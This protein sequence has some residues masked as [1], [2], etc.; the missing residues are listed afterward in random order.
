MKTTF[1]LLLCI[2]T[3]VL[4]AQGL[5]VTA[6][7]TDASCTANGRLEVDVGGGSGNYRYLLLSA[8]GETFPP[9]GGAIFE[10]LSPCSYELIVVDRTSGERD[11]TE[12]DIVAPDDPLSVTAEFMECETRIVTTGGAP[13]Y[14]IR[15]T[16]GGGPPVLV[17]RGPGSVE[18]G[19]LGDDALSGRVTDQ[20]GN[21]RNFVLEGSST[22]VKDYD[23]AQTAD[24][25]ILTAND[26]LGPFSYTI[27][28]DAGSFVN[29][30]GLFPSSQVGCDLRVSITGSCDNRPLV[31]SQE[32]I[33][34]VELSCVN[35]SEGTITLD[36]SPPGTTPYSV[37]VLADGVRI[38]STDLFI[39][40]IPR[41]TQ[42]L[43][44]SAVDGCGEEIRGMIRTTPNRVNV[45]DNTDDCRDE[46]LALNVGRS[47][48][49]ETDTPITIT[50]STC[51]DS[52]PYV[53]RESRTTVHINQGT[54]P[55][56]YALTVED[57]CGDRF[58]CRDTVLLDLLPACDSIKANVVQRFRCENGTESRRSILDP[59]TRYSLYGPDEGLVESGN[60]TGV[61]KDLLP[62]VY[63]VDATSACIATSAEVVISGSR[64]IDPSIIVRPQ[65]RRMEGGGCRVA[66]E[67]SIDRTDGPYILER[68]DDPAGP[69]VLNNLG[70]STCTFTEIPSDLGPGDYRLSSQRLCGEKLF[71]LPDLVEERIDSVIPVHTCLD[72]ASMLVVGLRRTKNDWIRYFANFGVQAT[73]QGG[74]DDI[75]RVD[76]RRFIGNV[77]NDLAPGEHLLEIAV[78]FSKSNC[79]IDTMTFT[80]PDYQPV[81]LAVAGNFICS[82]TGQA[83]LALSPQSG[84]APY[85]VRLIDCDDPGRI[86]KTYQLEAGEVAQAPTSRRGT[87][88]YIVRDDCGITADFQVE[89]RSLTDGLRIDYNCSPAVELST[90]TLGGAFEWSASD[91]SVLSRNTGIV[92]PESLRDRTYTLEVSLGSCVE[93]ETVSLPGR[94]ILPRLTVGGDTIVQCGTDAIVLSATVD[95]ASTFQFA[96]AAAGAE[97]RVNEPGTYT[98]KATNDLGC[99]VNEDVTV[100]SVLRPS[101]EITIASQNCPG[102]PATLA[103]LRNAGEDISWSPGGAAHDVLQV[104][105]TG[106]YFVTA[107]NE[108]GCVGRD[109]FVYIAPAPLA[110]AVQID[111][112]SCFGA[113]DGAVLLNGTGGSGELSY[114]F[115]GRTHADG[116]LLP[117]V[118]AG[119]YRLTLLD[120]NGCTRDTTVTVAQPDSLYIDL[121]P[122]QFIILGQETTVPISSNFDGYGQITSSPPAPDSTLRTGVL[123]LRVATTTRVTVTATDL[124]GCPATGEV[125]IAPSV[126]LS[127]YAPTAFSPNADGV[128]DRFTLLGPNDGVAGIGT[129]KVYD[130]WGT[131]VHEENDVNDFPGRGWDGRSATGRA[132]PTGV[133]LWYVTLVLI[134][135]S[136]RELSG[137]VTLVR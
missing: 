136:V 98:V 60:T 77:L 85:E 34:R 26:G 54:R 93:V 25:I 80:V 75:Y 103:V 89:V 133:Y 64:A 114:S 38:E 88:C 73:V 58:T 68:L 66:Y 129:V 72:S 31:R 122:D 49:G 59:T 116:S 104:M 42:Q 65:Y 62:G 48:F 67:V 137:E 17:T 9:Q 13:P 2:V 84:T 24:G 28:S 117:D 125:V 56:N 100:V 113:G 7:V 14:A 90:D 18:L 128:N 111:S 112:A 5:S 74:E 81:Q 82:S 102:E 44:I 40:G 76:G 110:L 87:Y 134:D 94:S 41:G 12:F 130:R 115:R 35:F 6:T 83:P 15:Y 43:D 120:S 96:G 109:S 127:V 108:Y 55:G 78:G 79:A 27:D 63:R 21:S 57:N 47:C 46:T 61:F 95:P 69:V 3:C 53:Q 32:I 118:A 99:T 131:L 106:R 121:G 126:S 70:G 37:V 29:T 10:T 52:G 1:T 119:T 92:V 33:S 50:C 91:G 101:P 16:V 105:Q 20:C 107:T 22:G 97:L 4:T 123:P 23:V 124:N 51:R 135:G 132:Q 71:T 36:V 39:T 11:T 45:P 86:L 19:T 8:C 30:T